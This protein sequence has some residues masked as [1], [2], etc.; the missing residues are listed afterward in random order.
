MIFEI[1]GE[2]YNII[3]IRF[4]MFLSYVYVH[5]EIFNYFENKFLANNFSVCSS[6]TNGYGITEY[7]KYDY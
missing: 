2:I 3:F 4:C 6:N 5:S 1:H 7:N